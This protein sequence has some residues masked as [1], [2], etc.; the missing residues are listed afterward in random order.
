MER[1][2]LS[3]HNVLHRD[4]DRQPLDW[5]QRVA[6]WVALPLHGPAGARKAKGPG[7]AAVR[8][9]TLFKLVSQL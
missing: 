7:P 5:A 2:D 9:A 3:L 6:P 4:G 8:P 1:C